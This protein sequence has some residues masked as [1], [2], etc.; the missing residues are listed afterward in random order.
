MPPPRRTA[1]RRFAKPSGDMQEGAGQ[2]RAGQQRAVA[3]FL[4][5]RLPFVPSPWP[6]VGDSNDLDENDL[7]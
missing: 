5:C 3:L 6:V 1:A 2:Q 4:W 7:Q